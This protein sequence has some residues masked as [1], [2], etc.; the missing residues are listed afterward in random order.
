MKLKMFCF[1]LLLALSVSA[2]FVLHPWADLQTYFDSKYRTSYTF[3][4]DFENVSSW[5][6]TSGNIVTNTTQYKQ[7]TQG[8]QWN[9]ENGTQV[10]AYKDISL[11][12]S[13]KHFQVWI[14]VDNTTSY[15]WVSFYFYVGT[16]SKYFYYTIPSDYTH[17]KVGW[18]KVSINKASA[19][20]YGGAVSSDWQAV[21]RVRIIVTPKTGQYARWIFDDFRMLSD[22]FLGGRITLVFDDAYTNVYTQAKP[23]IDSF[24]YAGVTA[25][26][27]DKIVEANRMTVSQLKELQNAG[28]DVI[29]HGKTHAA[30]TS[31]SVANLETELKDSQQWLLNNGFV[32]GS[33]FIVFPGNAW[34]DTVI[35]Y[36]KKYY[37]M[38]GRR[39]DYQENLPPSNE[40][41]VYARGVMNTT[42]VST[43]Q[44]WIDNAKT[45]NSWLILS[46]HEIVSPANSTYKTTPSD[47]QSILNYI[48]SQGITVATFSEIF[49]DLI[50]ISDNKIKIFSATHDITSVS[51]ASGK[52]TLTIDAPSGVLS[53]TRVYV[54]GKAKPTRVYATNGTLTWSYNASTKISTLNV[55]HIGPAEISFE[56]R[57]PGD[58]NGDGKVEAFDLTELMQAYGSTPA[59]SKWNLN[60]D[61]NRDNII[62]VLDLYL[63]SRN[64]GN[65][66]S[67]AKEVSIITVEATPKTTTFGNAIAV[68]GSITPKR[69]GVPVNIYYRFQGSSAWNMLAT[70]TTDSNSQYTFSWTPPHGT[71]ELIAN[72]TGDA[73]T[74]S[75]KS[76]VV[77]IRVNR[78]SSDIAISLSASSITLGETVTISGA[79]SPARS[80]AT[81]TIQYSVS[82]EKWSTLGIVTT[83]SNGEYTYADWKP[84]AAGE[85]KLR[86]SWEGDENTEP[87]TSVIR[88]LTVR[89]P[90]T[91]L[92]PIYAVAGIMVVALVVAVVLFFIKFRKSR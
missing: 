27:T 19:I 39:M 75:A 60:C 43:V 56:A 87:K 69:V 74:F 35:R 1:L 29:S 45:Y 38:A 31:M 84:E 4:D 7:G 63:L 77:L 48:N 22:A 30:L 20:S 5:T 78:V 23:I 13:R 71:Y 36:V 73:D 17:I 47:F 57:I 70:E 66:T 91:F 24:G 90:A 68:S 85:Y 52:L 64:Y 32:L 15:D 72:W 14:Y 50:G 81:V 62:S 40:Y 59:L 92:I 12:A 89:T 86:A 9:G 6:T 83:N 65:L 3:V 79:I 21:I 49:D 18:N 33:R 80:S 51:F 41:L 2:N 76:G 42:A 58:V 53:T 61:F 25:L 54:G 11:N 46:F 88:M 82:G 34:N 10:S 55:L 16:L 37:A 8:I 28:W 44:G 26:P 67:V